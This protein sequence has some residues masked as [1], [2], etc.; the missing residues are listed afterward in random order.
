MQPLRLHPR[1]AVI[2]RRSFHESTEESGSWCH[3]GRVVGNGPDLCDHGRVLL[4]LGGEPQLYQRIH[5]LDRGTGPVLHGLYGPDRHRAG[6]A[7]RHA[8]ERDRPDGKAQGY[9]GRQNRQL[10]RQSGP[11]RVL[12]HHAALQRGPGGQADERRSDHP[13]HEGAYVRHL[14]LAGHLLCTDRHQPDPDAGG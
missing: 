2:H 1:I 7:R 5:A 4:Y 8:G 6:S 9:H 12:L 11:D 14:H 3:P 10:H 13:G